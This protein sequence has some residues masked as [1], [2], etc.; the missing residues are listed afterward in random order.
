MK[1][2]VSKSDFREAFKKCGRGEQFSYEGLGVLFDYLEDI[3]ESGGGES[4]LDPIAYCCEFTEYKNIEEFQADYAGYETI[5][6][7]EWATAVLRIDD[8]SFIIVCF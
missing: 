4:E 6:D 5:E 2:T 8:D 1:Q 7:I 3:E